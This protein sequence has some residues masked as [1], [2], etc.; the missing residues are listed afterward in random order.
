MI[1]PDGTLRLPLNISESGKTST[2][3][4]ISAFAG[5]GV[6]HVAF[7]TGDIFAAVRA[8]RTRGFATLRIPPN[9]YDDL[10]ARWGLDDALLE[11]LQGHDVLY[12]RDAGG[13]LFQ[14]YSRSFEG[15]F[16]FEV[17]ERRGAQGFGA[18]N[19]SIR[20]AAQARG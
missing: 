5:A 6:H 16:F 4:F 8:L 11:E 19:A 1:S 3:R 12:D 13:E 18:I 2:G 9:Y 15:R 14:V 10:G 7:S 20:M 17:I